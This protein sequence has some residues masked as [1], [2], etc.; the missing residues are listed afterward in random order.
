M[1][2]AIPEE[3]R[4]LRAE[5]LALA[6]KATEGTAMDDTIAILGDFRSLLVRSLRDEALVARVHSGNS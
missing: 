2:Q 4:D 3:I 6:L 1:C 5:D